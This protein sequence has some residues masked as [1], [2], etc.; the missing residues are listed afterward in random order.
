VLRAAWTSIDS[1]SVAD[2][3]NASYFSPVDIQGKVGWDSAFGKF[4]S[5]IN[6]DWYLLGVHMKQDPSLCA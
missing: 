2:L 4:A 5:L 1:S 3:S 6:F